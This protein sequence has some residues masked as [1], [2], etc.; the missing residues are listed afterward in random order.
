MSVE[1]GE[2]VGEA[3]ETAAP[4]AVGAASAVIDFGAEIARSCRHGRVGQRLEVESQ[5]H[6][7]LLGAVVKVP[8]DASLR[9]VLG[10]HDP[11]GGRS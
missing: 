5:G 2:T 11:F 9:L 4:V 7:L 6:E 3:L 8:F 1:G 10:R